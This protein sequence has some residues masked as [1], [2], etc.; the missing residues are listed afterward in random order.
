MTEEVEA[1]LVLKET[2][3]WVIMDIADMALVSAMRATILM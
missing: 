2:N 1:V 3:V